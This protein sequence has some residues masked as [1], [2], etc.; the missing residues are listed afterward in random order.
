V[1]E[2]SLAHPAPQSTPDYVWR[3]RGLFET[4]REELQYLGG[5]RWIIPS[6]SA[7]GRLYEVRVGTRPER[8]CCECTGHQ[9]HGQCSHVVCADIARKNSAVCDCCGGRRAGGRSLPRFRKMMTCLRGSSETT[10]VMTVCRDTGHDAG[11]PPDGA[12][13]HW[14]RRVVIDEAKALDLAEW[15]GYVVEVFRARL[16]GDLGAH[17]GDLSRLAD[18][19]GL[20]GSERMALALAFTFEPQEGQRLGS[21]TVELSED[22]PED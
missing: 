22:T 17:P 9:R 19:L 5:G 18:E 8:N 20:N 21:E 4:Y 1:I 2:K 7:V 15:S 13:C 16:R 11:D 12:G 14:P 6:G 10:S 3:G